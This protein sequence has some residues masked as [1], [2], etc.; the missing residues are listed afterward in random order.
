V[1]D[2]PDQDEKTEDPTHKKLEDARKNGDVVKSQEVNSWFL[3]L[4][5]TL[6]VAMFAGDSARMLVDPLAVFLEKPHLIQVDGDGLTDAAKTL[7]LA[8]GAAVSLPILALVLGA[9]AGHFVQTGPLYSTESL[10]PKLSKISPL[11]GFKR[12]FSAQSFVNFGKSLAKLGIVGGAMTLILWPERERLI[13][14]VTMEPVAQLPLAQALS[15]KLL[16][17]VLAILAV[18][19]AADYVWQRQTW[20]KKQRMTMT[21]L[22]DEYKQMEGDPLVRAK[23]RQVRIERGRKR[24]MAAVPK[25]S[26]VITNPTH[27]AVALQYEKGMAAPVC[28][29]KGVDSVAFTIRKVAEEHG[30][31]IVENP[32]LARALHAGVEIDDAIPVEHY[33]AVAEVIGFVM[34]ARDRKRKT[35]GA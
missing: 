16:M 3:M 2:T 26:V 7:G 18:V 1:A 31:P 4:G 17:G 15:L 24:M 34:R 32:P 29:A 8:V 6:A 13:D 25:A 35:G 9:L 21:E 30:I 20:M 22:R 28:L 27:F 23:L 14:L 12:L 11:A 10:K 33:K 5:A 19:A